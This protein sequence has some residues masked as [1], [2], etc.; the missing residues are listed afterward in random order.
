LLSLWRIPDAET[1]QYMNF[2][3]EELTKTN[4]IVT[5]YQHAQKQMKALYPEEP[6]KWAGMVL[7]E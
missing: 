1:A 2:F 7:V 5:A 4:N 3:Y 6:L